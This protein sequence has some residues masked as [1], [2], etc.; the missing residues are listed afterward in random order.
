MLF[1]NLL[2]KFLGQHVNALYFWLNTE[3]FYFM[4]IHAF[5]KT[6]CVKK[7]KYLKLRAIAE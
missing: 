3:F 6:T 4:K 7:N 2:F 5:T 1:I